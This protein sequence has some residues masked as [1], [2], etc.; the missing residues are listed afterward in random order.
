MG[1]VVFLLIL[2]V[3]I[4]IAVATGGNKDDE[5]NAGANNATTLN[6]ASNITSTTAKPL[7]TT[8]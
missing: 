1:T 6:V 8:D 3:V 4:A 7:V 2:G 5:K